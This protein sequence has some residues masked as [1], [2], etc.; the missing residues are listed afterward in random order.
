MRQSYVLAAAFVLVVGASVASQAP[1]GV[2][3]GAFGE[4][5]TGS[6]TSQPG[7]VAMDHRNDNTRGVDVFVGGNWG[8]AF[9]GGT[10]FEGDKV[11]LSF[12]TFPAL[13]ALKVW[14]ALKEINNGNRLQQ[15]TVRNN[16]TGMAMMTANFS[17]QLVYTVQQRTPAMSCA[18]ATDLEVTPAPPMP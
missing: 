18:V 3:T 15:K 5:A 11:K 16:G 7:Q 10:V 17:G 6:P 13:C 14:M 1:Q 2:F 4:I 9:D 12:A 8:R